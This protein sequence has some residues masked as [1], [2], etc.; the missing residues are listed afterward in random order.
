MK[1]RRRAE[2]A[3]VARRISVALALTGTALVVGT[4]LLGDFGL[5]LLLF[6]AWSLL[7]YGVLSGV[8][9]GL[10]PWTAAGMGVAALAVEVGIRLAVFVFPSGSTAARSR[11]CSSLPLPPPPC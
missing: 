1:P 9:S 8:G 7:P 3:D 6:V 10:A 5:A 11:A 4:S 2:T